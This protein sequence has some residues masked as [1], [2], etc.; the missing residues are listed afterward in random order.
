MDFDYI[1]N[2]NSGFNLIKII[3][4]NSAKAFIIAIELVEFE[5]MTVFEFKEC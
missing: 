3:E 5:I 2:F 4:M 1:R